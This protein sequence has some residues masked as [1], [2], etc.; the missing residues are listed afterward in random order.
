VIAT[1]PCGDGS[2][3]PADTGSIADPAKIIAS[4]G[5]ERWGDLGM[6]IL[7]L[8]ALYGYQRRR[9]FNTARQS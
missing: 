2:A 7:T 3:S 1:N 8:A 5:P 6:L 9:K 4:F